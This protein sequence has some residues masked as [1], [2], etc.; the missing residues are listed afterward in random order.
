MMPKFDR[1]NNC[2]LNNFVQMKTFRDLFVEM[3]QEIDLI[4]IFNFQLEN[5]LFPLNLID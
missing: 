1:V 5:L 3:M 2:A 4:I